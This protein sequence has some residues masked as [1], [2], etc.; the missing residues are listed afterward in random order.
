MTKATEDRRLVRLTKIC[1]AFPEAQRALAGDHAKFH[2]RDKTFGYFLD[3]HH[4]DGIVAFTCK[5]GDGENA[6]LVKLD[7]SRFYLPAYLHHKGWVAVRLDRGKV[8]WEALG[9]LAVGSY[10]LVA[11]KRLVSRMQR[12]RR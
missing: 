10:C 8:D 6:E 3:N 5:V 11:P 9:E 2:V 12:D 7:P 4:G 1:L